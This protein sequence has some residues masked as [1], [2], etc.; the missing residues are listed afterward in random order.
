M[1]RITLRQLL[2]H[3]AEHSYGVPAFNINNMEQGLAILEAAKAVD[4]P[5]ILQASRGARSYAGDLMLA[6]MIE[7]LVETYPDI[8]ICLHLDHGNEESTCA[9]AIQHGFTSVMMD[10]SLKADAKSPADYDDNVAITRR[11][12]DMA[13]WVGASVEGELGVLGSLET[14]GGEQEDGHGLEGT[15]SHDQLLTDPDQAVDFVARTGVDALAIA[16]GTSHG[17]YKFSRKPDGDILAMGVIEEIHRRLPDTHLVMHG[18]S[19]VPQELQEVF[20]A[21]GGDMP[22]TWG[23]PIAE[24]QRGIRH[25]VRKINIDTDCRLAMTAAFRKVAMED[26]R[27][28]DPRKFLKPALEA[29]KTLCRDRFEAFGA[30]GHAASIKAVPLA[31]MARRYRSGALAPK[32]APLAQAHAAA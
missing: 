28:F 12:A 31:E 4:A 32:T 7:A 16:M 19:S 24:I 9:T 22:Q 30:A 27:E 29:M 8:P 20:N 26:P 10:G 25:G 14:G 17:A 21:H 11:V 6:K 23:V 15:V 2:D 1:A 3:A 13:H 5:V 18:S